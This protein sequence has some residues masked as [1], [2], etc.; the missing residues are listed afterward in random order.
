MWHQRS[1]S[2]FW[3][4]Y[5]NQFSGSALS[6]LTVKWVT[7]TDLL[8]DLFFFISNKC[9]CRLSCTASAS[10]VT[11]EACTPVERVLSHG[12]TR[13][14]INYSWVSEFIMQQEHDTPLIAWKLMTLLCQLAIMQYSPNVCGTHLMPIVAINVGTFTPQLF[15]RWFLLL[16]TLLFAVC[17]FHVLKK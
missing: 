15:I 12:E 14:H 5:T 16:L 10:K 17:F 1:Q 6:A 3:G 11:M 7:N 9:F 4:V 13:G 2:S 8:S